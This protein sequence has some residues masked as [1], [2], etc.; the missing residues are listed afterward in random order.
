MSN[1]TDA[2]IAA[3]LV[4]GSGGSGGEESDI[5]IIHLNFE[6]ETGMY[7]TDETFEECVSA[8][9]AGKVLFVLAPWDESYSDR[10][11]LVHGDDYGTS[12]SDITLFGAADVQIIQETLVYREFQFNNDGEVTYDSYRYTLTPAN[13]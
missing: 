8:W 1:L 4:G 2:L 5:F 11:L 9:L 7:Y 13:S 10:L 12:E 3:K 6:N